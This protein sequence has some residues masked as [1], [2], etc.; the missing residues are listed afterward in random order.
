M[1]E[2]EKTYFNSSV[3]RDDYRVVKDEAYALGI[4]VKKLISNII[5][6]YAE[7]RRKEGGIG[8]AEVS[9]KNHMEIV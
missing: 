6:T 7:T 3:S 9:S 8:E 4:T 5:H 1:S 2:E